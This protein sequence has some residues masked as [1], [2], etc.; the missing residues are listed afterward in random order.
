MVNLLAIQVKNNQ[1]VTLRTR[2]RTN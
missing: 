1:F 2:R